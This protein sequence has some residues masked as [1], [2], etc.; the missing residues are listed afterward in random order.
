MKIKNFIIFIMCCIIFAGCGAEIKN[1]ESSDGITITDS[2]NNSTIIPKNAKTAVCYGSFAE[3][4]L[5]SGGTLAGVTADALS[6]RKLDVGEAETIGTVKEINVEKLAAINPDYVILSADLKA[7]LDLKNSL[8]SLK[9]PYG[10]FRIDKFSDYSDMMKQFCTVNGRMDLFQKN[11]TEVSERINA[12]K[13]K[14][15]EKTDKTAL[16]MRAFSTGIKVKNDNLA[17]DILNE[18]SVVNIADKN[19]SLLQDLSVEHIIKED[20]DYIFV[21]TMGDEKKAEEY[22]K[23]NVENNPAWKEL[24]AVKKGNYKILPKQLFH[25]KPNNRWDES[26]EYLAKIIFPEIFE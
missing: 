13:E 19:P 10:Y 3:C 12:I 24:K 25:Y 22:L 1:S 9:I 8:D 23:N 26:Y 14:I 7:H 5:L 17:N 20:P 2:D 4:W 21:L 11:V 18:F 15:P 16:I 6:E